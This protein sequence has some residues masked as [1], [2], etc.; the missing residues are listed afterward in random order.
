VY[1]VAEAAHGGNGNGRGES[2]EVAQPITMD[3]AE[4]TTSFRT[5]S[6]FTLAV[7][8]LPF[9]VVPMMQRRRVFARQDALV[10][11]I[12]RAV[13][14]VGPAAAG[15]STSRWTSGEVI[16]GG[17]VPTVEDMR[18]LRAAMRREL[19]LDLCNYVMVELRLPQDLCERLKR[20][21]FEAWVVAYDLGTMYLHDPRA[22]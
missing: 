8:M 15:V 20:E 12:D 14:E 7:L 3:M 13:R 9:A 4:R 5:I 18:R 10:A 11:A 1:P 19:G 16:V 2:A 17:E 21:N 22:E 6:L